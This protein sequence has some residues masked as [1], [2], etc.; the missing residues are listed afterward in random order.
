MSWF[1][2]LLRFLAFITLCSLCGYFIAKTGAAA[3]IPSLISISLSGVC[4][5]LLGWTLAPWVWGE[6]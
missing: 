3:D 6:D 1:F 5:W 2:R 4:G